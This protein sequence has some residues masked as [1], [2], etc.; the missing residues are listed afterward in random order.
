MLL[1][2]IAYKPLEFLQ[3]VLN[4]LVQVDPLTSGSHF[5][6][7]CT[8]LYVVVHQVAYREGILLLGLFLLHLDP[9][10]LRMIMDFD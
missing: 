7:Q 4:V 8:E 9:H 3:I 5:I 10:D 1:P 2:L 6:Q